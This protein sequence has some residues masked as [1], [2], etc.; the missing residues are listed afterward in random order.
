MVAVLRRVACAPR[1]ME[2]SHL[3]SELD[4]MGSDD[5]DD[6]GAAGGASAVAR[7]QRK[8]RGKGEDSEALLA[9]GDAAAE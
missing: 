7:Q 1:S 9:G 8:G 3:F 5:E 6:D 4:A 2:T